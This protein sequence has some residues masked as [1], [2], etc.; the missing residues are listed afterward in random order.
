[1]PGDT[2]FYRDMVISPKERNVRARIYLR[3]RSAIARIRYTMEIS[4]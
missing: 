1:M 4:V 2:D 3:P